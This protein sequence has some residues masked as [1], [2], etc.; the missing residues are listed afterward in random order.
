M[1]HRIPAHKMPQRTSCIPPP[2]RGHGV[3][4]HVTGHEIYPRHEPLAHEALQMVLHD[5]GRSS[6]LFCHGLRGKKKKR[7]LSPKNLLSLSLSLS[8][9]ARKEGRRQRLIVWE[10]VGMRNGSRLFL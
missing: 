5:H 1:A 4:G 8:L 2:A 6:V 3:L 10:D 7:S 9:G